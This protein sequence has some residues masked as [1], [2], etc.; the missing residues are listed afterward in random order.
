MYITLLVKM[1]PDDL[2]RNRDVITVLMKR[3][4]IYAPYV[5][6]LTRHNRH[7]STYTY[8]SRDIITTRLNI[9]INIQ[10][11]SSHPFDLH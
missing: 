4:K 1:I 11:G 10:D 3:E 7:L 5:F 9:Y 8:T 6:R 2:N